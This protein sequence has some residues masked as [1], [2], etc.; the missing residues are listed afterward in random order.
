M[1]TL[2]NAARG[3]EKHP[4]IL[5]VWHFLMLLVGVITVI[6]VLIGLLLLSGWGVLLGVVAFMCG[7][8]TV[9]HGF[10]MIVAS[11]DAKSR[12]E[13]DREYADTGF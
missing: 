10:L 8:F 3:R 6:A 5:V 13:I 4:G 9:Y 7:G 2:W 1:K 11:N 12:E